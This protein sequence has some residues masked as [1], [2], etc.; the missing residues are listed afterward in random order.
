MPRSQSNRL[1]N[2]QA[3]GATI[4]ATDDGSEVTYDSKGPRDDKPWQKS[5]GERRSGKDC[6]ATVK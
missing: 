3:N 2:A 4:V 6:K 5:D 1:R